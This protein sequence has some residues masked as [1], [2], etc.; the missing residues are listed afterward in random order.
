MKVTNRP[1]TGRIRV[2]TSRPSAPSF[3]TMISDVETSPVGS[4][5]PLGPLSSI[6]PFDEGDLTD[7]RRRAVD[8]AQSM[9]DELDSIQQ[10]MIDG[11]ASPQKLQSLATKLQAMP[12]PVDPRI[13]AILGEIE[14]R[15]AVLL[16][17][18][19]L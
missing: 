18:Q 6:I 5:Q 11:L 19:G 4:S 17:Q 12:A 9:L 16:A 8:H 7:G 15:V 10:D 14:V 1:V 3:G 13:G 2:G